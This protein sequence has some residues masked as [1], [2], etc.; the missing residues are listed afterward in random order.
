MEDRLTP[1]AFYGSAIAA[2]I[3]LAL[4]LMLHSSWRD[5]STGPQLLT[6]SVAAAELVRPADDAPQTAADPPAPSGPAPSGDE[7]LAEYDTG[8]V[9]PDPLPVTRL[10]PDRFDPKPAAEEVART[11][12]NDETADAEPAPAVRDLD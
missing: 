2:L 10:D 1:G 9:A 7:Q 4:G 8:Y 12:V 5:H 3:G 11:D 6:R